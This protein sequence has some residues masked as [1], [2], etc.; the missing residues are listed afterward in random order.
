MLKALLYSSHIPEEGLYVG[1][2]ESG[3]LGARCGTGERTPVEGELG[4]Y[5]PSQ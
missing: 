2:H 1:K 4:W 3:R 5:F